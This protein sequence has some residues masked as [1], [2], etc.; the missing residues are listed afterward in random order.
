MQNTR[1]TMFLWIKQ[2]F[3]LFILLFFCSNLFLLSNTVLDVVYPRRSDSDD[4]ILIYSSTYNPIDFVILSNNKKMCIC[5]QNILE[6]NRSKVDTEL[7]FKYIL[8]NIVECDIL[9]SLFVLWVLVYLKARVD[10]R[11]SFCNT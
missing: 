8:T 11:S 2:N 3:S 7:M 1:L 4:K 10:G 5:R 6:C 9:F